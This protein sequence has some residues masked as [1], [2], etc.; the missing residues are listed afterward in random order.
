MAQAPAAEVRNDRNSAVTKFCLAMETHRRTQV[1]RVRTAKEMLDIFFPRDAHGAVIADRIFVHMPP[2]VRGPILAGWHVR[3]PKA[4]L[5]D[6]D[7][8]VKGVVEDALSAG[9]IDETMFEDGI[10]AQTFIDWVPL[11][12]WWR[13]WRSGKLTGTAVQAALATARD[14]AL[15]DDRWFLLHVD[16]R[17][18]KLKGTDTICDTLAKEQIVAWIRRVHE[19]GDASPAGLVA[20]LSWETVLAKTAHEALLFALD[21]FAK[22]AHLVGSVEG[23]AEAEAPPTDI[24]PDD[25]QAPA[26]P[27]QA[28]SPTAQSEP[29]P[30][31]AP[32]MPA[33]APARKK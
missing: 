17:G 4:A 33:A 26:W 15:F 30:P 16:G 11:P 7:D 31:P 22:K 2:T 9:D 25:P 32:L 23:E 24:P 12:E 8:R 27:G 18:G 6:S 14:L 28:L 19:S 3:G 1:G 5:R 20:A 13:F 21:A 29:P 10:D